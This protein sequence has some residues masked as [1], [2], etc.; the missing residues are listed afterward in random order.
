MREGPG[1]NGIDAIDAEARARLNAWGVASDAYDGCLCTRLAEP[2]RVELII[3]RWPTETVATEVADLNLRIALALAEKQLPAALARGILAAATQ[4]FVDR[5]RPLDPYDW[6]SLAR[7][8]QSL[9]TARIEDYVAALAADGPLVPALE[10]GEV[11][12]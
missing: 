1:I 5:V 3:G 10:D 6:L 12:R 4:D 7:A 9:A 11:T 8:A 2:G